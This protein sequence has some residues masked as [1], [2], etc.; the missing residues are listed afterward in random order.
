VTDAVRVTDVLLPGVGVQVEQV[1]TGD[2]EV[3]LV[4]RSPAVSAACPE[5][6]QRSSL[7]HSYYRRRP[8]DRPVAGPH[9]RLERARRLVCGNDRCSRRTFAEQIPAL[10][11]RYARRPNALTAQL[12]D[13]AL[14]LGG[15]AGARL[16]RRMAITTGKDT[17]LRLIRALPVSQPGPVA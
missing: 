10:T 13:S 16:S 15:R 11:R 8:A 4:V 9:V 1:A 14:F 12:T 2:T 6:G 5:C 3:C 17:L 7:V